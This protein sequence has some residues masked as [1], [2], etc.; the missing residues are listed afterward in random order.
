MIKKKKKLMSLGSSCMRKN[1]CIRKESKRVW[2]SC[3]TQLQSQNVLD[4]SNDACIVV[5]LLAWM[6]YRWWYAISRVGKPFD[7]PIPKLVLRPF[8]NSH[9]LCCKCNIIMS[10]CSLQSY[11][12]TDPYYP[13]QYHQS[14]HTWENTTSYHQH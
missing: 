5:V 7:T 14:Q 4:S 1:W 12:P 8:V 3:T 11:K 2:L 10:K 6:V 9:E 13:G